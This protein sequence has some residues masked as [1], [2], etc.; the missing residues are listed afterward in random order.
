[1]R[2]RPKATP[3]ETIGCKHPWAK[4]FERNPLS[5]WVQAPLSQTLWAKMAARVKNPLSQN[6]WAKMAIGVA[7][8]TPLVDMHGA[9][10]LNHQFKIGR[11]PLSRIRMAAISRFLS[12][13]SSCSNYKIWRTN[14]KRQPILEFVGFASYIL[15]FI[16]LTT[17]LNAKK[18]LDW[19]IL[20]ILK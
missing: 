15:V 6:I 14:N 1:M 2:G 20:R 4:P 5:Q 7:L 18:R 13:A 17:I 12:F 10:R 19:G 11:Y 3:G 16:M 9:D 8:G